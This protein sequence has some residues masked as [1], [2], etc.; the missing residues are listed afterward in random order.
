MKRRTTYLLTVVFIAA[1]FVFSSCRKDEEP[2]V[3]PTVTK[4]DV[5]PTSQPTRAPATATPESSSE[6]ETAPT[7]E[8][9]VEP[10]LE[11][12]WQP[13]LIYSSPAPGEE[14]LLDGA[15]TLRFDQPMDEVSVEEALTVQ[16]AEDGGSVEGVISWP[17]TDTVIFTPSQEL[18]RKQDYKVELSD[19]AKGQNG[20]T[21]REPVS[22]RLQTVGFLEVSQVIPA[23]DT[24]E[25][26][27]DA[28]ITVVFN[29][30][31]VPLVST[32]DQSNRADPLSI[33]PEVQGE[34]EW[35]STSIYRF[36]P[37]TAFAGGQNYQITIPAGL[38]D[39]TG[40]LLDV[41]YVWDFTTE[42]PK[43]VSTTPYDGEENV[44]PSQP[45]TV[46]F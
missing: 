22:L 33:Q 2:T 18:E 44:D 20:K 38:E 11:I 12:D 37:D 41:D 4:S 19:K 46:T 29:R 13:Q 1:L 9:E 34:G 40:G 26:Q 24:S 6:P 21:M 32:G 35:V 8:E 42:G 25:V 31:V 17:R 14:A 28:S 16:T 5:E 3:T 15:I 23:P 39:V 45:I 43:V 7:P 30:P 36:T 10:V 27:S